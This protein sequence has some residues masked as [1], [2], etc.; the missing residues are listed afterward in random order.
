VGEAQRIADL[1]S[2]AEAGGITAKLVEEWASRQKDPVFE[3]HILSLVSEHHPPARRGD[4]HPPP[5]AADIADDN[6]CTVDEV[7][8]TAHWALATRHDLSED[9]RSQLLF[10]TNLVRLRLAENGERP[11]IRE[12]GGFVSSVPGQLAHGRDRVLKPAI[13]KLDA[14]VEAVEKVMAEDA[15]WAFCAFASR[16]E[17]ARLVDEMKEAASRLRAFKEQLRASDSGGSGVVVAQWELL[18][19]SLAKKAWEINE[20]REA[21]IW[22]QE[23]EGIAKQDSPFEMFA[24]AWLRL[25]GARSPMVALRETPHLDGFCFSSEWKPATEG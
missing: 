6:E 23:Q 7:W 21:R 22:K 2:G 13:N 17:L 8:K 16:D 20:G 4:K 18:A 19:V 15:T 10:S 1:L 3:L 5:S 9:S 24:H 25:L 14:A 11:R 12:G